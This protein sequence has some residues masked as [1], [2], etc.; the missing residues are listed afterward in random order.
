MVQRDAPTPALPQG[1]GSNSGSFVLLPPPSGG[2]AGEG[3]TREAKMV[4][5]DAHTPA[6]PQRGKE[7]FGDSPGQSDQAAAATRTDMAPM[8]WIRACSVSPA[9]IGPT[10]CGVPVISTSPGCKV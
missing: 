1:G 6:L 8:P 5:R 2:R 9:T 10:P 7:Q 4:Q 3:G